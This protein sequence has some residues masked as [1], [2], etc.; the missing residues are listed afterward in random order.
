MH[1]LID[2]LRCK[3]FWNQDFLTNSKPTLLLRNCQHN[4][5]NNNTTKRYNISRKI[6]KAHYNA[7]RNIK[8]QEQ[9]IFFFLSNK[10]CLFK[11]W[12]QTK[13]KA[14]RYVKLIKRRIY[15]VLTHFVGLVIV[16]S[17]RYVNWLYVS[18]SND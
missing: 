12:Y 7:V 3:K 11:K 10:L 2:K 15:F 9:A 14:K 13:L 5:N 4:N 1:K 17:I 16:I 18:N 8:E 6:E